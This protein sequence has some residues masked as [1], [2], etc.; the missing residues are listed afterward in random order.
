MISFSPAPR[1]GSNVDKVAEATQ[2]VRE[3]EPELAVD[4]P[5]STTPLPSPR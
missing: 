3:R 1:A 5:C 2:I 4:G